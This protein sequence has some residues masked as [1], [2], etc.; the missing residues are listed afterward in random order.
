[1]K[2]Q[3]EDHFEVLRKILK[4]PESS[5]REMAE[6]LGFSLGKLNYCLIE[7]KKKGLVKIKSLREIESYT[8]INSKA[9]IEW[10]RFGINMTQET[11]YKDIFKFTPG[12]TKIF[13][14]KE[15]KFIETV[16][17]RVMPTEPIKFDAKELYQLLEN[18]M[19][20]HFQ[21][22]H[23]FGLY[24]SGGI[25]SMTILHF[26]LKHDIPFHSITTGNRTKHMNNKHN[27]HDK[28]DHK[29]NF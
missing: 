21:G 12:E 1:M 5:Q 7:L 15:N 3:K 22:V 19:L 20:E 13:D 25:D 8:M 6:E 18:T 2:I 23:K 9:F 4:K 16:W 11:L 24:L 17:N 29:L 28:S 26:L 14:I 10:C 27:V